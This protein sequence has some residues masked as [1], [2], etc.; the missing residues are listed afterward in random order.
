MPETRRYFAY[1]SN[2]DAAQ[3][4]LRCP[5][6]SCLGRAMLEGFR[7]V[8]MSRGYA[9]IVPLQGARVHGLLWTLT[10]ADEARLDRYESVA[11]N[12]YRKEAV[13]V[14]AG[15]GGLLPVF[16]YIARE[17][18]SGAPRNGYLERI[19]RAAEV[20]GLPDAYIA[21]LRTWFPAARGQGASTC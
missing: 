20:C 1:G 11:Q 2:L 10:P 3:M 6:A 16:T 18:D 5:D 4:A 13:T 14:R 7:F 15:E 21:E 8:I 9:T 17:T 19:V 12:H